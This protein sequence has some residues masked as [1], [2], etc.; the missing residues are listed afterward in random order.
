[1]QNSTIS[2][3]ISPQDTDGRSLSTMFLELPDQEEYPEYYKVIPHPIDMEQIHQKVV[4]DVYA[5]EQEFIHDFEI[6]FQVKIQL[7]IR[8]VHKFRA[9]GE[10]F[11][12]EISLN[13]FPLPVYTSIWN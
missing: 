5:N 9:E 10:K 12:F 3:Q 8:L 6:L 4:T 1:M 7:L 11:I 2:S 13:I